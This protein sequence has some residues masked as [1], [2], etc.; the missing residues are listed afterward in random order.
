[1][2]SPS[3]F[4]RNLLPEALAEIVVLADTHEVRADDPSTVEFAS[5][6]RQTARAARA[7][8]RAESLSSDAFVH[9]GDLVQDYPDSPDFAESFGRVAQRLKK[10]HPQL[11]LVAGN[12]DVGDKPDC[13]MPT[14]PTTSAGLQ[15]L[16]R[17]F[18][19]SWYR[20]EVA[21]LAAYVMNTQIMNTGLAADRRQARWFEQALEREPRK[22]R[23][24]F[25]HLPLYLSTPGEPDIGHY[26]NLGEPARTWL[27]RLIKKH[28][29]EVVFAGHVHTRFYDRIGRARYH[30]LGSP[31]FTRPG[32]AHMFSSSPPPEQGRDDQP[33]LGFGLLRIH[34]RGSALHWIRTGGEDSLKSKPGHKRVLTPVSGERQPSPLGFTLCHALSSRHD[35]PMAWPSQTRVSVRNDHPILALIEMGAGWVRTPWRDFLDPYQ[36]ERLKL[37]KSERV[38][39]IAIVDLPEIAGIWKH[40][41]TLFSVAA[42]IEVRLARGERLDERTCRA[43]ERLRKQGTSLTLSPVLPGTQIPGKQHPRTGTAWAWDNLNQAQSAIAVTGLTVDRWRILTPTEPLPADARMGLDLSIEFTDDDQANLCQAAWGMAQ[44]AAGHD[45]RLSLYPLR[46]LDRTMDR[47][48]GAL[49][50][51]CNPRSVFSALRLLNAILFPSVEKRR[52]TFLLTGAPERWRLVG[53]TKTE[54]NFFGPGNDSAPGGPPLPGRHMQTRLYHLADGTV[55]NLKTNARPKPPRGQPILLVSEPTQ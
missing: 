37:L 1:M 22:R 16:H 23:L 51:L 12:H 17:S 40:Q 25:I 4:D 39:P 55:Q 43:L 48:Q 15:A 21:Q 52:R 50:T 54:I 44:A 42:G 32:F 41:K 36:R 18:G 31:S 20:F 6:K 34:A 46:D 35:I 29:F 2:G 28:R 11:R 26:D 14:H 13:R 19:R 3:E 38:T 30:I 27:L 49:D 9:L 33:K 5:R 7:F 24:L 8:Q 53:W 47:H 10:A 45:R